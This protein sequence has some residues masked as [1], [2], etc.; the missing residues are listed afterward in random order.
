METRRAFGLLFIDVS[1]AVVIGTVLGEVAVKYNAPVYEFVILWLVSFAATFGAT[2][3]KFSRV[4]C[5]VR[6]RMKNSLKWPISAKVVN[7]LCWAA[8]FSLIVMFPSMYQYLVL[9][10][11]GLGN[12]STYLLMKKYSRLENR[13]QM[14]VG[15]LSLA[16]IPISIGIGMTL[17]VFRHDLSVFLSRMLIAL[18]YAA[19]GIY[20]V[21]SK[22]DLTHNA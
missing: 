18:A 7:G 2:F 10:G 17:F 21:T 3:R 15:L 13:E 22:K 20:A 14:I 16:S 9:L 19:G 11:I 6:A 12:F 5:S 4:V 1:I 8:P